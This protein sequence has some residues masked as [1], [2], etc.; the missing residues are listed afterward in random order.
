[1]EMKMN[2][3]HV[4]NRQNTDSLKWNYPEAFFPAQGLLPLWVADMDF[5]SPPCVIRA[6]GERASHGVYGYPATAL[7]CAEV[8]VEWVRKR[9][10]W[11][12]EKDWILFSP[13]VV[14]ALAASV[15]SLSNP[16]DVV[17]VPSPVYHPFFE[18]VKS[19]GRTL[20]LSGLI[21]ENGRYC[22]DF[23]D[24]EKR[25][26][27]GAR[28]MILC[29]PHN[30]V[31]RVWTMPELQRLAELCERYEVIL[32]S[33]EIHA[34]LTL[35]GSR[36]V[37][38]ASM[39]PGIAARTITFG[40]PSKTFNIPG[41][42]C[43]YVIIPDASLREKV[44]GFLQGLHLDTPNIFAMT[45]LRAAYSEEGEEWLR[46]LMPYLEENVKHMENFLHEKLP[47]LHMTRPEATYLAWLDCR[48]LG[49]APEA[50][51]EFMMREAAL[52]VVR[53]DLFGPGGEGFVRINFAC[54][55]ST[56]QEGLERLERVIPQ[57]RERCS[58]ML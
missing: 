41:L 33:D 2:F 43:S 34:D 11:A 53:G 56:L 22:L 19:Q 17:V 55:R 5:Q 20:R 30:P 42:Q 26:Q 54:P 14:S 9:H 29:S 8:V 27:A 4:V 45:A 44:R 35:F 38:I 1:M 13:G 21:H 47:M 40:A 6:L 48:A 15:S 23:E 39:S 50:L 25:F 18:V 57:P 36:H 46:E 3:D 58:V 10:G 24:L 12:I 49:L 37:P 32:L 16:D 7:G 51:H 28:M 31:G 52:A